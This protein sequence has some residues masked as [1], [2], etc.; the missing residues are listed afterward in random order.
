MRKDIAT[1]ILLILLLEADISQILTAHAKYHILYFR[2]TGYHNTT[3]DMA[4]HITT[5]PLIQI[6]LLQVASFGCKFSS[7]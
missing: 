6:P 3:H 4:T 2:L 7:R 1:V 5:L